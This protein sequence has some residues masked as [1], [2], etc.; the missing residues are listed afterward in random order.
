MSIST[1]TGLRICGAALS[2]ALAA[3]PL[4]AADKVTPAPPAPVPAQILTARKVFISNAGATVAALDILFKCSW[5]ANEPYNQ[6][7][8]AMKSW[9]RFEIVSAPADADLVLEIRFDTYLFGLTILDSKTH[10]ILWTIA[11][12]VEVAAREKT[13]ERNFGQ[14][15][16]NL[17][18]DL[19]ALAAQPGAG[20]SANN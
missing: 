19:K 6:F 13:Y 2:I 14:A 3:L 5:D 7:Y 16:A 20:G 11:Q 12:P 10:F 15:V 8:A 4:L 9:G 1:V 18:G 17:V